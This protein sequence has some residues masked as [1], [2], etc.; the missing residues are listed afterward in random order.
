[1]AQD[2]IDAEFET[3]ARGDLPADPHS[4]IEGNEPSSPDE[5]ISLLKSEASDNARPSILIQKLYVS[6]VVVAA[7]L[8]FLLSGGHVLFTGGAWTKPGDLTLQVQTSRPEPQA[9]RGDVVTVSATVRNGSDA[10]RRIPDVIMVFRSKTGNGNLTYRLSRGETL[11][12]GKSLAFTVRMA[13]KSGY[14]QAPDL[15]FDTS[16]FNGV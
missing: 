16:G 13:K 5:Q 8:S 2:I 1:V 11:E 12:P 15:R 9:V 4:R 3:I 7:A 14:T 6:G 10:S